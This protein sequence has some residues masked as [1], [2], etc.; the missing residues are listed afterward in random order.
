[1]L[2]GTRSP[3]TPRSGVDAYVG[4]LNRF[5]QDDMHYGLGYLTA[6]EIRVLGRRVETARTTHQGA[7]EVIDIKVPSI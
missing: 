1:M 2:H 6:E 5:L 7:S 4:V 3:V